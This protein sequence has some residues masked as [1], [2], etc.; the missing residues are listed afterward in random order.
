MSILASSVLVS[1]IP[2]LSLK[3]HRRRRSEG[4][5]LGSSP[6]I[7]FTRKVR[8]GINEDGENRF[9]ISLL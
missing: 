9:D 6:P 8:N 1:S 4:R 5:V 2:L 7:H 3:E